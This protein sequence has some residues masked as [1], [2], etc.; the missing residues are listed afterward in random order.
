MG[1]LIRLWKRLSYKP[2][3]NLGSILTP[4]IVIAA[5]IGVGLWECINLYLVTVVDY[6][7]NA[8]DAS[9][10]QWKLLTYSSDRGQIYDT[11]GFPLASN[12]YDYTVV[13]TPR[14]V[15]SKK[16]LDR[17]SI[18][19]GFINILGVTYEK[20][21]SILPVKQPDGT[22]GDDKRAQVEGRDICKNVSLEKKEELEAFL[23]EYEIGGVGFIAVPQR[24]YNYGSLASQVIGFAKNDGTTVKGLYGLEAYYNQ[25]LSGNN[26]YRYSEV[27]EFTDGVLPYSE[28]TV[29]PAVDGNNLVL[30]IDVSIQR[31]TEEA[32]RNAY[33]KYKPRDG[34][35]AIVMNPYTAAVYAMVSMPDYDLNDPYAQP[36]NMSDEDWL[37]MSDDEQ[38]KYIMGN[39]WRNRCVSDT[40][41][42]GS[43]FKALT[44][45][46]ALEENLTNEDEVFSDAPIAVST[47]HTISCWLQKS[48][49]YNHGNETLFKAFQNSCNPIFTQ[50]AQRI[51][52]S[53]YYKYV[54]M[55]GFYNATGIDLPAEGKGIF[56]TNPSQIDMS[57]LSY[58]ESSTVTPIQLI[59]SYC[60]IINGGDLMVPHVVKYITDSEGNI[61]DEI[62]PEVV[63]TVF[64]DETCARVRKMLEAVVTDGTGTAGQVPGYSVAG[65]TS[66]STIETGEMRGAHVL[67]FS[68]YAPSEDPQ[69]AVLVV[70]N[71][72]ENN[73]VGSSA[74]ASTAADIVA[75]TLSYMKVPRVFT[76]EEYTKL[77][78]KYYVQYVI[79]KTAADAASQISINGQTPIYGTEDMDADSIIAF[80][81]P[82]YSHMLY[83]TGIVIM[84]PD[85]VTQDQ[86]LTTR[87]PNLSGMSA[88]ECIEALR[89]VNLNCIVEGDIAGVCVSQSVA[90][91]TKALAGDIIKVSLVETSYVNP[92]D[93]DSGNSGDNGAG[94]TGEDGVIEGEDGIL[95]TENTEAETG[96]NNG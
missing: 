45:C 24:Y 54:R 78:K 60:A 14:M 64:S 33:N 39:C 13:C 5:A 37:I 77:L 63:R 30:N 92:Q 8:R 20:M 2:Y 83:Q 32:C 34:I 79:G 51:G 88:I 35:C 89:Q 81:H 72:P 46:M 85:G 21:D 10:R 61:V 87:V 66:T 36:F 42:P 25:T 57:V 91:G 73:S 49:H 71:K 44:T 70:L 90:S 59:M 68:C 94:G 50:L 69:I 62:E 38:I 28:A 43:T 52:I 82:D 17:T 74:A 48:K 41:E 23:K 40:Y 4:M 76:E 11:N 27:D 80:T 26:G 18:I 15:V 86:M 47:T 12:T 7:S 1:L 56:H 31:I 93:G 67:S 29:E 84:Y 6:D 53:K 3:N 96:E 22:W 95:T 19:N 9:A 58:G 65:K 16:E 55:L 75:G